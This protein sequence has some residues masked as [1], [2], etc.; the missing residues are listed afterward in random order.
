MQVC[1]WNSCYLMRLVEN[2]QVS[3]YGGGEIK[4]VLFSCLFFNNKVSLLVE[5]ECGYG[6]E[7][8]R[9]EGQEI[10]VWG[11]LK[12]NRKGKYMQY[13]LVLLYVYL[14]FTD[15]RFMRLVSIVGFLF[16]NVQLYWGMSCGCCY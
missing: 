7:E 3:K 11:S 10:D 1:N 4:K 9:I 5:G 14:R 6:V 15:M 2:R 12:V 8:M 16:R 13:Y